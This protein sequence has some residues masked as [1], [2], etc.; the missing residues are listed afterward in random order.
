MYVKIEPTGC[1]ERKGLIQIRF[2]FFLEKNDYK[3][4]ERHLHAP[5]VPPEGYTGEVDE[6]GGAR[7]PK[8]FKKW[9]DGLPKQWVDA[10][11]HCHLER[12]EPDTP[13]DEIMDYGEARLHEAYIKWAT[14]SELDLK[15]EPSKYPV[16]SQ[17]DTKRKAAI[18]DK[19]NHVNMVDL[20]RKINDSSD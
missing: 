13:M 11:F 2:D 8:A 10:P 17:I 14:N 7:D 16:P 12:F 4:E 6:H 15:N 20:V 19:V 18:I 5:I 1:H 9:L 3:Y